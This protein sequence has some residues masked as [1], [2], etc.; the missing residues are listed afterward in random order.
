[1]DDFVPGAVLRGGVGLWIVCLD[2][3]WWWIEVV[4][5]LRAVDS[6]VGVAAVHT[7]VAVG[8]VMVN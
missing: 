2:V 4:V 8:R 6:V 7:F 3:W 1:L 5:G